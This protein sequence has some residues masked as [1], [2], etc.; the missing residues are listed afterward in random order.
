MPNLLVCLILTTPI[1]AASDAPTVTP[2]RA[3]LDGL[4]PRAAV[5]S[6]G[7]VHVVVFRGPIERGDLHYVRSKDGA[8]SFGAPLRITTDESRTRASSPASCAQLALGR[9]GRVHVAWNGLPDADAPAAMYYARLDEKS[10]AFEAPRN[11]IGEHPGIEGG[12]AIAADGEGRVWVAW[13]AP[14]KPDGGEAERAVFAVQ[15]GDDGKSFAAEQQISLDGTGVGACCNVLVFP[16]GSGT[17]GVVYRQARRGKFGDRVFHARDTLFY[18]KGPAGV[19]YR[20]LDEWEAPTCAPTSY[21]FAASPSGPLVA[22]ETDGAVHWLRPSVGVEP[23]PTVT[24]PGDSKA[25]RSPTVAINPKGEVLL[26]WIAAPSP[27]ASS[28]ATTSGVLEWCVFAADGAPL[29]KSAGRREG[30]STS[31]VPAAVALGSGEFVLFY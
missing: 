13:H 18:S 24:P 3:P 8:K 25:R 17:L 31:T 16:H 23:T 12:G 26:A 10:S 9:G 21:S 29:E 28:D 27:S 6:N 22:Y 11:V 30:A 5:D 7:A 19:G 20:A 2:L 15:S 4:Q 14:S 1:F